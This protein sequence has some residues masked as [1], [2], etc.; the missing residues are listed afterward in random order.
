MEVIHLEGSEGIATVKS[1]LVMRNGGVILYPTD[2]LYGLGADAFSDDAVDKVYAIKGR[3]AGKPMH[4][5]CADLA[6]VEEFAEVND[7]ARK[8]AAKFLPGPLTLVLKKKDRVTGGIA[9]NMLTIGVRIPKD[10]FCLETAKA[11][12]KPFTATSANVASQTTGRFVEEILHQLGHPK[13]L[14]LIIDAGTL[15][16]RS[17]SSVVDVSDGQLRILRVGAM[18]KALIESAVA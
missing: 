14:E 6:M 13:E 4:A 5:I 2:T 11:L 15:P 7:L 8:L 12:G 3:D 1:A 18:S 17:P 9:R 16:Q 10:S